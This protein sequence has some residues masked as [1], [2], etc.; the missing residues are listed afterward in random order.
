MA[1]GHDGDPQDNDINRLVTYILTT[2]DLYDV[3][4]ASELIRLGQFC[5][6][7]ASVGGSRLANARGID[8]AFDALMGKVFHSIG[9]HSNERGNLRV[10]REIMA[11]V[12]SRAISQRSRAIAQGKK[13]WH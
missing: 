8:N 7:V 1:E 11:S 6:I 9:D 10:M 3:Q 5:P 13:S 12:G 4:T 2:F